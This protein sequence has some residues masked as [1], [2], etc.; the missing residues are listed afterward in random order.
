MGSWICNKT[1][2]WQKTVV[3]SVLSNHP[4]QSVDTIRYIV[5]CT[6][7]LQLEVFKQWN[8]VADSQWFFLAISAKNNKF[9]YLNLILGKLRVTDPNRCLV[10]KPMVDSLFAQ[11]D[12]FC[13][14]LWFRSYE[15]KCVHLSSIFTGMSTSLHSNFTWIGSFPINHYWHQTTR[16]NGLPNGEDRILLRSLVWHNTRVLRTDGQTDRWICHCSTYS[17]CKASFVAHCK[18]LLFRLFRPHMKSVS[19]HTLH[20]KKLKQWIQP[21]AT[22]RQPSERHKVSSTYS[23]YILV[24]YIHWSEWHGSAN[25]D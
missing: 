25:R 14:L 21:F 20:C 18:N 19:C 10:G 12:L 13:Y 15:A 7:T 5:D 16:D 17:A 11:T 22:Y 24:L 23:T 4:C 9:G 3:G 2:L 6:K 8:F 1:P